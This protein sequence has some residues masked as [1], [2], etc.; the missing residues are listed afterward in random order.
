MDA[1]LHAIVSNYD[2]LFRQL[3]LFNLSQ[4]QLLQ[5]ICDDASEADLRAHLDSTLLK[6]TY[7]ANEEEGDFAEFTREERKNGKARLGPESPDMLARGRVYEKA[8]GKA[9]HNT[10]I[11]KFLVMELE[12]DTNLTLLELEFARSSSPKDCMLGCDM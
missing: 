4:K 1:Y 11:E 6:I 8:L 7:G 10:R 5:A 9:R 2:I 3:H 12:K